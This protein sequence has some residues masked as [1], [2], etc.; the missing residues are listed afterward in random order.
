MSVT[1][2]GSYVHVASLSL[3]RVQDAFMSWY[4]TKP[5][6]RGPGDQGSCR[7][8]G[9]MTHLPLGLEPGTLPPGPV[10]G[11]RSVLSR[12]LELLDSVCISS[13]S[14]S[15]SPPS[16]SC[17]PAPFLPCS[18]LQKGPYSSWLHP[19]HA[20]TVFCGEML[21]LPRNFRQ[22]LRVPFYR[23]NSCLKTCLPP[24]WGSTGPRAYQASTLP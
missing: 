17:C 1:V 11:A 22:L 15:Q 12:G 8:R 16:L 6:I 4:P 13:R 21:C 20:L 18:L 3:E 5:Q 10:H 19:T 2:L 7:A 24:C 9:T 14:L 23:V